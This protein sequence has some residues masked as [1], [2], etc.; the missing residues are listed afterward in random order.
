M[1][2]LFFLKILFIHETHT[3]IE[4]DTQEEGEAGS[5]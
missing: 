1:T 4:A 5:M 3:E 2:I